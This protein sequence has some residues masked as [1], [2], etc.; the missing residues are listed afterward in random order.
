M[1]NTWSILTEARKRRKGIADTLSVDL[2]PVQEKFSG[3]SIDSWRQNGH[4][5][6][7]SIHSIMSRVGGFPASLARYLVA[8]YS[9]PGELVVDPFCGKGTTLYEAAIMGRPSI[10]GDVAPDAVIVSRQVQQCPARRGREL[11]RESEG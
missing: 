3:L 9:S 5:R 2:P 1:E 6:G 7:D 10:G 11:H 8:A 4:Y